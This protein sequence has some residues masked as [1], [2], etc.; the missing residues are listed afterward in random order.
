[1][2]V[3][4]PFFW[5]FSL[6]QTALGAL[7]QTHGRLLCEDSWTALDANHTPCVDTH[8]TIFGVSLVLKRIILLS[9][10]ETV[11]AQEASGMYIE[12]LSLQDVPLRQNGG[13]KSRSGPM[14]SLLEGT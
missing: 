1:M 9:H 10:E 6:L 14:Q 7:E 12:G 2:K 8:R 5:F 11:G 13:A 4:F 3:V